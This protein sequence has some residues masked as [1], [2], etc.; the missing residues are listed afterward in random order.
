MVRATVFLLLTLSLAAAAQA[1]SVRVPSDVAATHLKSNPAPEYPPL[2]QAAR[3]QG[4]VILHISIDE[5]GNVSPIRVVH[6]HPMLVAAAMD[7][8]RRWKYSPFIEAGAPISVITVVAVRFGNPVPHDAEDKAEIAFQDNFWAAIEHAQATL[9]AKDLDATGKSLDEA[10]RLLSSGN[11]SIHLPERWRWTMCEGELDRHQN[12]AADAEQRYKEALALQKD[13]PDGP[14]AAASLSSLGSL[15]YDTNKPDLARD[16][17]MKGISKYEKNYKAAS[18]N[19]NAQ[20]V[21]GRAIAVDSWILSELASQQHD[22]AEAARQCKS[23]LQY[24]SSLNP[25]DQKIATCER[26]LAAPS[27]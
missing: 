13:N 8:V 19:P 26:M 10:Q 21:Y 22:Q 4:N 23:V 1:T 6:G 12:R 14:E 17:L 7:G 27:Q 11:A 3:I 20:A 5:N 25:S 24:R 15:Y 2:A 16:S 9:D 18:R